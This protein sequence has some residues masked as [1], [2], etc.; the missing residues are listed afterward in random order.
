MGDGDRM[1]VAE[2]Y[3]SEWKLKN[4][5]GVLFVTYIRIFFG[6]CYV[7][8]PYEEIPCFFWSLSRNISKYVGYFHIR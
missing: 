8:I 2:N 5:F 6:H 7:T 1:L 3:F 4:D